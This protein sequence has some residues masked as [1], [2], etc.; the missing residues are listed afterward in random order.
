MA[1][2]TEMKSEMY[3][4]YL[5]SSPLVWMRVASIFEVVSAIGFAAG[6]LYVNTKTD[7]H[8]WLLYTRSSYG[9]EVIKCHLSD[10]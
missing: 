9:V 2:D 10:S 8:P 4:T 7:Q 5:A 1:D 6:D 3:L